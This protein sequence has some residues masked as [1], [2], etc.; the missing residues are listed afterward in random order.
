VNRLGDGRN[1]NPG[2][3]F[4]GSAVV[5]PLGAEVSGIDAHAALDEIARMATS[6]HRSVARF[7][8]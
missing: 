5:S 6:L 8:Y 2:T 1:V 4:G 7:R 3:I